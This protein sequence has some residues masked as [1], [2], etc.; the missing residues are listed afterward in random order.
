MSAP[1]G[2]HPVQETL[3]GIAREIGRTIARALPPG[4]VFTLSLHTVGDGGFTAYMSNARRGRA[5]APRAALPQQV[6]LDGGRHCLREH[7]E[8]AAG[9]G[10]R[11]R[12][13]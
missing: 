2:K 1:E 8:R 11:A 7:P 3:E 9:G 4:V 6:P 5:P 10:H 13:R 12:R